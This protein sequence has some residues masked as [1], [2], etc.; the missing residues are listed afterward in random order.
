MKTKKII[1]LTIFIFITINILNGSLE[2]NPYYSEKISQVNGYLNLN[3]DLLQI[4]LKGKT[5]EDIPLSIKGDFSLSKNKSKIPGNIEIQCDLKILS[6]I[7]TIKMPFLASGK[8]KILAR[9]AITPF[10]WSISD[11]R[12]DISVPE[13]LVVIKKYPLFF[14]NTRILFLPETANIEKSQV[15]IN[16]ISFDLSGKIKN[17]SR[18]EIF[19]Q[20]A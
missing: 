3:K 7:K 17:F 20:R 16:N 8:T 19:P 4:N 14:K 12:L 13:A 18:P 5:L 1:T 2:K 9:L 10:S 11:Y 15:S 6:A